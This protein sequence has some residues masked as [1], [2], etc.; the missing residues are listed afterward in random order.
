MADDQDVANQVRELVALFK[1]AH[2]DEI[3]RARAAIRSDRVNA[4]VLDGAKKWTPAG[5]L[6]TAVAK[7]TGVGSTTF[8]ERV[9]ELLAAG[10][11]EKDGGGPTTKYR[12]TGLI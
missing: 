7:K 6:R 1:L 2:R 4:A 12:A 5:K 10:V 8:N 9:A 3:D 11:L